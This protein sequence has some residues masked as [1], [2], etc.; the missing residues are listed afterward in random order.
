MNFVKGM[1]SVAG[2]VVDDLSALPPAAN[3]VTAILGAIPGDVLPPLPN[4]PPPPP[5]H[6]Q[7]PS[8]RARY[9]ADLQ[10]P[11]P[12]LLLARVRR[13][14]SEGR[15]LP[16]GDTAGTVS[17]IVSRYTASTASGPN[18]QSK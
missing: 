10:I 13:V 9:F 18:G 7:H 6:R 12:P 14:G 15:I 3:P 5:L 4:S 1:T 17:T 2:G 8:A 16:R 11:Q